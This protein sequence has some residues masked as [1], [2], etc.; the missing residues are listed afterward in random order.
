M[1]D[2][3]KQDLDLITEVLDG[4]LTHKD[5]L[6]IVD[7]IEATDRLKETFVNSYRVDDHV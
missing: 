4:M 6:P 2:D 7:A 1:S 3:L 5:G